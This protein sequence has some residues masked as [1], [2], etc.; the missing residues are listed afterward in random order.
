MY[1][2][3][4]RRLKR[5]ITNYL[6]SITMVIKLIS[7][8]KKCM[9]SPLLNDFKKHSKKNDSINKK[10][11]FYTIALIEISKISIINNISNDIKES[12]IN[13][14]WKIKINAIHKSNYSYYNYSD[15]IIVYKDLY[16]NISYTSIN[17]N[18]SITK[19]NININKTYFNLCKKKVF[20]DDTKYKRN[21]KH[22]ISSIMLYY[23]RVNV[24][25]WYI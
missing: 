9:I 8:I 23:N 5:S 4:W 22:K 10:L 20:E 21:L 14:I 16:K 1:V 6:I 24:H 12:K 13:S 18:N 19:T 7:I 3:R 17:E 15:N 25:Y 2:F 11:L